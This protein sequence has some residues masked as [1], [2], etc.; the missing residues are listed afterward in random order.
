MIRRPPRS[1]RTD[2]LFPYPTLFRSA[3]VIIPAVMLV[4]ASMEYLPEDRLDRSGEQFCDDFLE[5]QGGFCFDMTDVDERVYFSDTINVGATAMFWG[6][7]LA[8][9]VVPQG[10]TGWTIGKLITG[11]RVVGEDGRAPGLGKAQLRW[12]LWVLDGDRQS[13]RLNSSH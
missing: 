10:L 9:L 1:T 4:T 7:T 2:T 6:A 3:L 11:L 8:M 5:D 12:A 13:P